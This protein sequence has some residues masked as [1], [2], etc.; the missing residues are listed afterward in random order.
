[1][2]LMNW[3]VLLA[4]INAAIIGGCALALGFDWALAK[5]KREK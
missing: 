2:D 5:W 4:L 1:M 3:F